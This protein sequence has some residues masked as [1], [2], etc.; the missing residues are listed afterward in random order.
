[1]SRVKVP[2][3]AEILTDYDL[4]LEQYLPP[5]SPLL[6]GFCVDAFSAI[7]PGVAHSPSSDSDI[8]DK[9]VTFFIRQNIDYR[10]LEPEHQCT[11]TFH[12]RC[13]PAEFHSSFLGMLQ[14]L[15]LN[16]RNKMIQD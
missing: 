8:W 10:R 2:S 4:V 15:Q 6:A 3:E 16:L 14:H 9:S 13:S 5:S 1:M 7:K 12:D 11:S